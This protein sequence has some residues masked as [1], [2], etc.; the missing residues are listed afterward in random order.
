M[1]TLVILLCAALLASAF[2]H[3]ALGAQDEARPEKAQAVRPKR[4]AKAPKA[5]KT[6]KTAGKPAL[7][8]EE[9]LS[10]YS[11]MRRET[12]SPA[13]TEARQGGDRPDLRDSYQS[14]ATSWKVDLSLDP[15]RLQDDSPVRFN[16]GRETV[17]DPMTK[18]ELTPRADPLKA[19]QSLQDLNLKGALENLG[20]KAEIQV[21]VLKF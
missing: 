6:P 2:G 11:A 9:M 21:D 4:T 13:R 17:I 18:K 19:K 8:R 10:P 16:L 12:I 20:G 14:N 1:R 7:S 3:P 5:P 15:K